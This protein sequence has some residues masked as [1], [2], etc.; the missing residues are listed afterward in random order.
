MENVFIRRFAEL[1]D[2]A[3]AL[4]A[5]RKKAYNRLHDEERERIDS[6][7]F[8]KWKVSAKSLL[9]RTCGPDSQH[10]RHFQETENGFYATEIQILEKMRAVFAAAREDFEGGYLLS[11]RTL[12]Q[13]EVFDSEL[14]QARELLT[15]G[16]A[17]PAA[18]VAGTVLE[19]CL[20]DLCSKNHCSHGKLDKMNADLAKAGAYNSIMQKRITHIAAIRNSAAHGNKAEFKAED[21]G[22]MIDEIERFLGHYLT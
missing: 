17:A 11:M 19:T 20:R 2:A 10:A 12:V 14:D 22:P 3:G 8:L 9:D 5:N 21:V 4:F 16:Y 13:A 15:S 7:G 1:T 6:N 18:V